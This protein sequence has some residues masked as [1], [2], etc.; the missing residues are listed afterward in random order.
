MNPMIVAK[1]R[2]ARLVRE[3]TTPVYTTVTKPRV[4]EHITAVEI[5][6]DLGRFW[7]HMPDSEVDEF[8]SRYPGDLSDIDHSGRCWCQ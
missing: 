2:T 4:R 5:D 6:G 7:A 3:A 1:A 8:C